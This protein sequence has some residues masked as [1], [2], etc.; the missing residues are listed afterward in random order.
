[1]V[2][3]ILFGS[4]ILLI[5]LRVPIG[6]CLGLSALL[7]IEL[8]PNTANASLFIKSAVMGGNNFP[9]VAVPLFILAGDIMLAGGLSRRVIG[10]A[11]QLVGGFKAGLS[12]I[13][14]IACMFF[15]AISGSSPATVAAIGSNMIPEMVKRGYPKDYAAALTAASGI[16][17]VMIPP[18]IPFIIYGVTANQSIGALFMAG[19]IPGILF[20]VLYMLVA[21]YKVKDFVLIAES[22]LIDVQVVNNNQSITKKIR[23]SGF[24]ALLVPI[25]ILGGIYSGAFTPTEAAGVAV[26]YALFISI[27]VYREITIRQL[28]KILA[29]SSMTAA[30]CLIMVVMAFSFGR[31]LTIEQIPNQVAQFIV[32]LSDN[33]LVIIAA[34]NVLLLLVGMFME[35]IAAI[36]ILTP[37]LLPIMISIGV[38][39]VHFGVILTCN[40]AIG[41]CTPPLGV[42]LFVASG[43]GDTPI[44]KIVSAI[45]P[46]L[47][48]ML[49]ALFLV[50]NIPALSLWLPTQFL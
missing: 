31:L 44:E 7:V 42:N 9:L 28:P 49:I 25:I 36:I 38:D 8:L 1:M 6:V 14:I 34:V 45:I 29:R 30:T 16:V 21:Q 26:I 12:Y 13:N 27:F 24:W 4:F 3:I 15:A 40:L 32:Q 11:A 18:S 5:L 35:T 39:P 37:I 20:S 50:S 23:E 48:V 22:K 43:I 41:F 33:K 2:S 17:G 47:M 10:S 46:F 19:I